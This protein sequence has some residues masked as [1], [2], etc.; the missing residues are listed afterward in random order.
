MDKIMFSFHMFLLNDFI[1]ARQQH[2][3]VVFMLAAGVIVHIY[4]KE[5]ICTQ[6]SGPQSKNF[7]Q[8]YSFVELKWPYKRPH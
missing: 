5:E 6:L 3:S 1:H 4:L 2:F 7:N 8:I